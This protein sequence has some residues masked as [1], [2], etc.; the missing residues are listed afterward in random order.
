MLYNIDKQIPFNFI[1]DLFLGLLSLV[2]AYVIA[3]LVRKVF[4]RITKKTPPSKKNI[5]NLLCKICFVS[6][7]GLGIVS[8]LAKWGFDIRAIIA[9]LGLTGFAIGFALKDSISSAIAGIFII[10]YQPFKAGDYITIS[11]KEGT[12]TKIDIRHTILTSKNIKHVVPNSKILSE[13]I[14]ITTRC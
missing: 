6:I 13:I 14:S 11:G 8:A 4:F 3:L 12:V 10:L 9:S 1:I 7:I 5:I 2:F